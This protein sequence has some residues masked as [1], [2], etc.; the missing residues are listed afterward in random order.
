MADSECMTIPVPDQSMRQS[1]QA[2]YRQTKD[3][4]EFE[5]VE[6]VLYSNL[7]EDFPIRHL[8]PPMKVGPETPRSNEHC[9]AGICRSIQFE[10]FSS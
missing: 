3:Q 4:A 10:G 7:A 5:E 8:Q 2:R 6:Y 1:V 9:L